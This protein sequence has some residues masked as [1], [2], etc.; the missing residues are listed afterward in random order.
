MLFFCLRINLLV[1]QKLQV[2]VNVY[3]SG[4]M[5]LCIDVLGML[6]SAIQFSQPLNLQITGLGCINCYSKFFHAGILIAKKKLFQNTSPSG[7]GGGSVF[8]VSNCN[9]HVYWKSVSFHLLNF[10]YPC[11]IFKY[12]NQNNIKLPNFFYLGHARFSSLLER[13]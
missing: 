6:C 7:C 12:F 5:Q 13:S 2:C 9:Y 11:E 4:I 3:Q 10:Q 1:V 8:F